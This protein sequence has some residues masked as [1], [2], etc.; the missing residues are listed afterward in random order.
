MLR[1]LAFLGTLVA[2]TTASSWIIT[3]EA[4]CP[5]SLIR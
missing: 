2:S 3:E 1:L 4:K 5:S